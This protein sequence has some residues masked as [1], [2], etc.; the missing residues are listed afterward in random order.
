MNGA[1]F[2]SVSCFTVVIEQFLNFAEAPGVQLCSVLFEA[3]LM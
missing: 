2:C 1:P 3:I